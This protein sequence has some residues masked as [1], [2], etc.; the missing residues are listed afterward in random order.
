MSKNLDHRRFTAPFKI[1][2]RI[3]TVIFVVSTLFIS[4]LLQAS[5]PAKP[6]ISVASSYV[7]PADSWELVRDNDEVKV[8]TRDVDG[9][10]IKAFRGETEIAAELTQLMAKMDDTPTDSR[11][12][13]QCP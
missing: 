12:M 5:T 7:P 13:P 10:K 1:L 4:S 3:G 6:T 8:W 2:H 11:W 9:S